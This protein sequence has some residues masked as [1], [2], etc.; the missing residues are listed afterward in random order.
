VALVTNDPGDPPRLPLLH[1]DELDDEQRTAYEA[2]TGGPRATRSGSA[3]FVDGEGRLLG[4]FNPML[5]S[6]AVGTPL[7]ALGAA[8]RFRT[9]FSRREREIAILVVAAHHR[10][11]YE[12]YAHERIGRE[13]GLTEAELTTLRTGGD[14]VLADAR[15]RIIHA[16]TRSIIA[17]HDLSDALYADAAATLG[18]ATVVELVTLIGYYAAL[19][20]Q[21]RIFRVDVPPGETAPRWD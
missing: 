6:P 2:L 11:D 1:P 8:L 21:L 13:A 12:W 4:P 17:D 9:S 16:A 15:E 14:P 7:Q 18:R 3:R 5:Y 20:M 19:A 10:S